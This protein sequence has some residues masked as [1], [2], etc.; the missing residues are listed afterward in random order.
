MAAAE[1]VDFVDRADSVL[2]I[3]VGRNSRHDIVDRNALM[4]EFINNGLD[5]FLFFGRNA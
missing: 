4:V 5:D 1:V 2:Q 3:E